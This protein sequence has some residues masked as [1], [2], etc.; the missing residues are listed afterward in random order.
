MHAVGTKNSHPSALFQCPTFLFKALSL[1][2][3]FFR[4]NYSVGLNVAV[5]GLKSDIS[6]C[7]L[8]LIEDKLYEL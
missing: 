5:M 1:I 4:R 3:K 7:L 2:C 8:S 6:P